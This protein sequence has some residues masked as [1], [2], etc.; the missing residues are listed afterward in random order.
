MSVEKARD[1]SVVLLLN[2]VIE[3]T[4]HLQL[5]QDSLNNVAFWTDRLIIS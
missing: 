1:K 2:F 5:K 3:S 4:C